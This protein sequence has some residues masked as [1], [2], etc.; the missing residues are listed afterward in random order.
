VLKPTDKD[1]AMLWW[2]AVLQVCLPLLLLSSYT[3]S[4]RVALGE[5]EGFQGRSQYFRRRF[6]MTN[7]LEGV[8]QD[9]WLLEG[10]NNL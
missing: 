9:V 2:Q 1:E 3:V 6:Q 4:R 7:I 8:E 5:V 10:L